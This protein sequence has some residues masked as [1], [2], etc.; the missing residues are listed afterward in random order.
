MLM[1]KF[2]QIL[3]DPPHDSGKVLV[4]HVFIFLFQFVKFGK[5]G[6]RDIELNGRAIFIRDADPVPNPSEYVIIYKNN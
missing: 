3:T 6:D 2:R 4:F 5:V 1:N